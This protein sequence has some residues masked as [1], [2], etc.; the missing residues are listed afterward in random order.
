MSTQL[1]LK[2]PWRTSQSRR[3]L[4][5]LPVTA[6]ITMGADIATAGTRVPTASAFDFHLLRR[7]KRIVLITE[8]RPTDERHGDR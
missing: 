5:P 7:L 8:E 1:H 4:A 3:T 6:G 2:T